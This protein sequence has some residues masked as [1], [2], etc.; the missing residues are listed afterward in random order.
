M[1]L[2]MDPLITCQDYLY[3]SGTRTG[4][5]NSNNSSNIQGIEFA[6]KSGISGTRL[7]CSYVES[8]GM[9]PVQYYRHN[10]IGSGNLDWFCSS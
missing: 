2:Y 10:P 1:I 5:F 3:P 4:N 8:M 6:Q 9:L 7:Y